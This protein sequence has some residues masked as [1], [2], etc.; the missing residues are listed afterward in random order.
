V[1]CGSGAA[2]A[3]DPFYS[4]AAVERLLL[5]YDWLIRHG[6]ASASSG[7]G[8]RTNPAHG[9]PP[10]QEEGGFE[11]G[12]AI[13]ADLDYGIATLEPSVARVVR[14]FAHGFADS[15][16]AQQL[17]RSRSTIKAWREDGI[18]RISREL[19]Y[20]G[21]DDR[22]ILDGAAHAAWRAEA[23]QQIAVLLDFCPRVGP[24]GAHCPVCRSVYVGE[25][26]HPKESLRGR[27]ES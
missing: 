18:L 23:A 22:L 16:L 17:H 8:G 26:Q 25:G 1:R 27:V 4:P 11:T 2:A 10:V 24:I 21:D 7:R 14:G 15:R 13:K 12:V 5:A 6:R 20:Q 9:K 3:G 19:G